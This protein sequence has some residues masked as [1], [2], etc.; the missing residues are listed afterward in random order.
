MRKYQSTRLAIRCWIRSIALITLFT[1]I[2]FALQNPP[3]SVTQPPPPGSTRSLRWFPATANGARFISPRE[4]QIVYPGE[5]I[6]IKL[7]VDS[8]IKPV[9]GVGI[10]SPMGD[11]NEIREG[12]PYSFTFKIPDKDLSGSSNRLIGFQDLTLFG[13][14]VGRGN[15]F[16]LATT[17][18]DVEEPDLPVSLSVV[19]SHSPGGLDFYGLG[20]DDHISI[21][22]RFSDGHEFDVTESTYLS[23]SSE[24]PAVAFVDDEGTVTSV[25][26]GQ[27][28]I[29]VTY[30]IGKQRKQI[31]FPVTV[32]VVASSQRIDVSPAF[33][34][35]GEIPSN[36]ASKP[37][38]I[39]ITNHTH[40]KIHMFKLEPMGGFLVGPENCSETD[41]PASGSCTI[42]VTFEPIRAGPVH[43]NIFVPNSRDGI[44]SISLF[45]KGI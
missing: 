5:T 1:I 24:N 45:G 13:T 40:E 30:A 11:S 6:P 26:A 14:I 39:T 9:K 36:T 17:T 7:T 12:P 41:L 3:P 38:Q 25:G 37:L 2:C 31:L 19:L 15:D 28:N 4:G 43:S 33:F 8:G 32:R 35:F 29:K 34:N 27:T 21:Y 10:V 18:V 42:T 23:V 20:N 22:G 16:D 44:L